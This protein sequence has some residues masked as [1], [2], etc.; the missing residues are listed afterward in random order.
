MRA[1][2]CLRGRRGD[3]ARR[4]ICHQ[5]SSQAPG[6]GPFSFLRFSSAVAVEGNGQATA[7]LT[8]GKRR[9][10]DGPVSPQ[11]GRRGDPG[12]LP[13]MSADLCRLLL[14]QTRRP[15]ST[16]KG[17]TPIV[18]P[19]RGSQA[20]RRGSAVQLWKTC[21]SCKI[22]PQFIPN[23]T[24]RHHHAEN[25]GFR[26]RTRRRMELFTPHSTESNRARSLS[27]EAAE[28]EI[29]LRTANSH[30]QTPRARSPAAQIICR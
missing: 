3:R 24:R 27:V 9:K 17:L 15:E 11:A 5:R 25:L 28:G 22:C 18:S 16:R 19:D 4:K 7:A 23:T 29:L 6:A 14:Y 8:P 10:Q 2:P 20:R 13:L 12:R 21:V 1:A 26:C 30:L